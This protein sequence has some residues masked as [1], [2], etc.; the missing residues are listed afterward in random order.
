M[1][2]LKTAL[3]HTGSRL[4]L[5]L[6]ATLL[7][8]ALAFV[9]GQLVAWVYM[10]THSGLSYSRNFTQSLV[11]LTMIATLVMLVIG[12]SIVTAFGLIGALALIRFRNVLKDTRDTVFVFA[13][14]VLGMAVG[15]QRYAVAL[16]GIPII[17]MV[18]V[19]MGATAFGA[20]RVQEAHLTCALLHDTADR[21]GFTRVLQRFCRRFQEVSVRAGPSASELVYTLRLRDR[22]RN[23]ELVEEL[24]RVA[25]VAEVI[26][27]PGQESLEP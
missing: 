19:L 21:A 7:S 18:A 15:S 25:G 20:R 1:H 22:R 5:S 10:R 17:L 4:D 24:Q 2:E 11:L 6:E 13:A 14:L 23:T 12:S 16:V 27:L 9:L 8:L 26:L 3:E